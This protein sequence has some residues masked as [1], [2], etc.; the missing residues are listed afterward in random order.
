MATF[1]PIIVDNIP[2]L[3]NAVWHVGVDPV[4]CT[5]FLLDT[6]TGSA[7]DLEDH[8]PDTAPSGFVWNLNSAGTQS[9]SS[10][11]NI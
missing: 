7:V 8:T 10:R 9:L 5:H 11:L 4:T 3:Q 2:E 1:P 6:F